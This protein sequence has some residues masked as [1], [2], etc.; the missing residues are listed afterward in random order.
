MTIRGNDGEGG[1]GRQ[2]PGPEHSP[3]EKGEMWEFLLVLRELLRTVEDPPLRTKHARLPLHDML[4]ILITKVFFGFSSADHRLFLELLHP[5]LRPP[6][7]IPHRNSI[8]N[9]MRLEW[10]RPILEALV[11][12]SSKPLIPYSGVLFA[13]D[14]TPIL[15]PGY[16]MSR[17]RKTG[18]LYERREWIR[19]HMICDVLTGV[20]AAARADSKSVAEKKYFKV[21]I[22]ETI[23]LGFHVEAVTADNNYCTKENA[24]W[25]RQERHIEPNLT[26]KKNA[27]KSKK[28]SDP[29]WD[30]NYERAK[31]EDPEVRIK[32]H[33]R[34]VIES[35]NAFIKAKYGGEVL[36]KSAAGQYNEAL[37]KV[38][39]ANLIV[40]IRDSW[41]MGFT[42]KFEK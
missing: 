23:S 34:A 25:A 18:K 27:K 9:Y 20:V 29:A 36:S 21:L 17:N 11:N 33:R 41:A 31:S 38:I 37:C 1:E 15:A 26:V 40:L 2:T 39:C 12:T 16:Y 19:L 5:D 35:V 22:D 28:N 7:W 4:F 30:E 8:T 6:E 10:L 32:F 42:P 24:R 13:I 3:K 14:S